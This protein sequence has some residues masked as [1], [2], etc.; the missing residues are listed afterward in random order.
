MLFNDPHSPSCPSDQPSGLE[1]MR[2]GHNQ[3]E[4]WGM[5]YKVNVNKVMKNRTIYLQNKHCY[6]TATL[7]V[8]LTKVE[9][10]KLNSKK[11]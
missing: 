7:N 11:T 9:L 1:S 8:F 4:P 3:K 5:V 10:Y 2:D 6:K